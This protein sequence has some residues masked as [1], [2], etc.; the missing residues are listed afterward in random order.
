LAPL[1]KA[2]IKAYLGDSAG[3]Y[4]ITHEFTLDLDTP[5]SAVPVLE[6]TSTDGEFK[7]FPV[8]LGDYTP[9]CIPS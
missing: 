2:T 8:P 5:N 7:P 6:A 1:S 3:Q 9:K 4:P